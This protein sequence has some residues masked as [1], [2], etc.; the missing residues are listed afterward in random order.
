MARQFMV[1]MT[2]N[3]GKN[4]LII[5]CG[6]LNCNA[7]T[8]TKSPMVLELKETVSK[9]PEFASMAD[10]IDDEYGPLC[11]ILSGNGED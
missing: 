1:E 5:F 9:S 2:Q 7:A 6:D 8:D 3:V 11:S 10:E 4:D